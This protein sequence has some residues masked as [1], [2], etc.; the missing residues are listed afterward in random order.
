MLRA[1]LMVLLQVV[2]MGIAMDSRVMA[3]ARAVAESVGPMAEA[4]PVAVW[5]LPA[6]A[7]A[8]PHSS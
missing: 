7:I 8:K 5:A 1:V 6:V 2:V 4:W 3:L